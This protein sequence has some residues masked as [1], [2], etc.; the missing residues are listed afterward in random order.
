MAVHV[1]DEGDG[2]FHVQAGTLSFLMDAADR[3]ADGPRSADLLLAALATCTAGTMRAF[4]AVAGIQGLR[5]VDVVAD[6]V[7]AT[8]PQR[9]Q[10]ISLRIAIRGDLT[11][12]QIAQL[13]RAG[14]H[15]KI[16]NTLHR[17]PEITV[18]VVRDL[19]PGD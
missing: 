3:S 7:S 18:D 12:E 6:A 15:C 5:G 9:L 16:H 8:K 14:T 1:R 2:S 4:A 11:V 17:E 19:S 13:T 10:E